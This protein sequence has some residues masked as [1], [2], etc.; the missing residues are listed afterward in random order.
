MG[1]AGLALLSQ[2]LV[3][4]QSAPATSGTP[5]N[6]LP[7]DAV[8]EGVWEDIQ[9]GD[10]LTLRRDK[11]KLN[12]ATVIDKQ[13]AEEFTVQSSAWDGN[14]LA[15]RY[16]IPSKD[17][18]IVATIDQ[19]AEG[20]LTGRWQLDDNT[21]SGEFTYKKIMDIAPAK[22]PEIKSSNEPIARV[23]RIRSDAIVIA[24]GNMAKIRMH[25]K[26]Y[27]LL[28]GQRVSLKVFFPMLTIARCSLEKGKEGLR[29]QLSEGMPVYK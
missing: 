3:F 1:V 26:L 8:L 19:F 15:F 18:R 27:I 23:Y 28:K 13:S 20:K 16:A 21:N 11:G 10:L 4:C 7:S 5:L 29:N 2:N 22:A 9:W 17:T 24:S 25:D 12:V 6:Q 14:T